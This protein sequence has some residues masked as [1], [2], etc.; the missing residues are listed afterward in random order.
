MDEKIW[1]EMFGATERQPLVFHRKPDNPKVV[2]IRKPFQW[3]GHDCICFEYW[4]RSD[5]VVICTKCEAEMGYFTP[6]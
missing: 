6:K 2:P 3:L 5:N 4:I 1:R